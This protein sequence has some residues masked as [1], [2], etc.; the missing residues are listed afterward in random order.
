MSK[1]LMDNGEEVT[2]YILPQ[3]CK[4]S[5]VTGSVTIRFFLLARWSLGTHRKRLQEF[6]YEDQNILGIWH[7]IGKM[8]LDVLKD[9]DAFIFKVKKSKTNFFGLLDYPSGGNHLRIDAVLHPRRF[10]SLAS[11]S[12]WCKILQI[13][14]IECTVRLKKED[15]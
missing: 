6:L 5:V 15:S 1:L 13:L 9:H 2:K 4:L 11:L 14:C 3:N 10:E 7:V 8:V 12:W